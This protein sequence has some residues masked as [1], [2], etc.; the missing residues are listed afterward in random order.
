MANEKQV[1]EAKLT[2]GVQAPQPSPSAAAAVGAVGP[3]ALAAAE[4][5]GEADQIA[6]PAPAMDASG[7]LTHDEI[8]TLTKLV[9]KVG[10]VDA[11]IR[12]MKLHPEVKGDTA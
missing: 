5:S 6:K 7:A 9:Q 12:W 2:G 1:D 10:G 4:V 11:L 8:E 3:G